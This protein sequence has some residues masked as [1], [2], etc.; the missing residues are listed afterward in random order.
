MFTLKID[1]GNA[2]FGE[3][4]EERN[5]EVGRIIAALGDRL[6]NEP[7][8]EGSITLMDA[9]GNTVGSARFET[10]PSA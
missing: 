9:F 1:T 4:L 6:A 10:S 2:A 5:A 7:P 3:T 8:R